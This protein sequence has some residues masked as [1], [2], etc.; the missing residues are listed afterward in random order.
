VLELESNWLTIRRNRVKVRVFPTDHEQK[1]IHLR[2]KRMPGAKIA[3]RLGTSENAVKVAASTA[4]KRIGFLALKFALEHPEF[5][6]YLAR[7]R[8]KKFILSNAQLTDP[9]SPSGQSAPV[10]SR[11]LAAV[12]NQHGRFQA[13]G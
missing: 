3:K 2:E 5:R 6:T 1:V 7:R 11:I 4:G 12:I 8:A 9:P 10:K 13:R